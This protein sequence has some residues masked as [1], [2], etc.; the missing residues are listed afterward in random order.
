MLTNQ[1]S[2]HPLSQVKQQT[3]GHRMICFPFAW[4]IGGSQVRESLSVMPA[5]LI[6]HW[7]DVPEISASEKT[8]LYGLFR[9]QREKGFYIFGGL[10]ISRQKG[11][12]IIFYY[13]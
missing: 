6:L 12:N 9:Q 4:Q 8:V 10:V 13:Q 7:S 11:I 5:I 1:F 3:P 2:N